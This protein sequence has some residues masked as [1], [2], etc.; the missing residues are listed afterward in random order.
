M[1]SLGDFFQ[2]QSLTEA[3]TLQEQQADLLQLPEASGYQLLATVCPLAPHTV[4]NDSALCDNKYMSN[5]TKTSLQSL[6]D[7]NFL[8]YASYV[9][10][11][12]AIPFLEDGL[13]PVQRRILHTLYE[14]DDGK[15]HKVANVV[16]MTMRYHPH[17]D[18][19]IEAALVHMAQKDYL[20]ERQGNFGNILTGDPAS[21]ARYIECRLSD[22]A[23]ETLFHPEITAYVDSYDGRNREPVVLPARIPLLLMSGTDGIAVGLATKILPHNFSELLKAQI[24]ILKGESFEIYPDFPQGGLLDVSQYQRGKGKVRV[25]ARIEIKDAKT[26]VI[27]EIPFGSTT[28]SLIASIEGA[29][30]KGKL[31]IASI[32]DYTAEQVEIELRAGHGTQAEELLERLYLYTDCEH[33]LHLQPFLIC[34]QRP[35]ELD[36]HEILEENTRQLVYL[37]GQELSC[38]LARLQRKYREQVLV[39]IFIENK[40]YLSLEQAAD[41]PELKALLRAW[42]EPLLDERF[43]PV[44][45]ED[46]DKL[47]NIPIRRISRFDSEKALAELQKTREAIE[48]VQRKLQHI[49]QTTIAWLEDLLRRYGP[50]YP[51]QTSLESFETINVTAVAIQ[52]QKV[53][54]DPDSRYLGTQIKTDQPV[55]CSTF[56]KLLLIYGHGIYQV[57]DIPDKLFI[58]GDL[59]YFGRQA[60]Q[61]VFSALYRDSSGVYFMKRFSISKFILNKEYAW[62]PENAELVYFSADPDPV[63]KLLFEPRKRARVSEQYLDF[64]EM[65]VKSVSSRGNKVAERPI[66][67]VMPVPREVYEQSVLPKQALCSA[68]SLLDILQPAGRDPADSLSVIPATPFG[69]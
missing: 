42:L 64:R 24:A 3:A 32:N 53:G 61:T 14:I 48:V 66:L 41:L 67:Q 54:Y 47:L 19:S 15:F 9:I 57:L 33:T 31:K 44:P 23:R 1:P 16:G 26:L 34:H 56:D 35:V 63:V 49:N 29:I 27:R 7:L 43:I 55:L 22:L 65:L 50:R 13:K 68:P 8:E 20:I 62:L 18:A 6:I 5:I 59:L 45:D 37:L 52:D 11:D 46:L 10:K 28:E 2:R 4:V 17:G 12:R 36:V 40:L 69:N 51:R 60:Q 30:H 58:K 38:D 21:A 39:Q 25:R